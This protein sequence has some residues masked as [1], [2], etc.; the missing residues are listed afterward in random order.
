MARPITIEEQ[1]E[2]FNEACARYE[3]DAEFHYL[4]DRAVAFCVPK[5]INE[6]INA[7]M[8]EAATTSAAFALILAEKEV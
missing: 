6:S 1:Y 3:N 4:V 2:A 7:A 5:T 8:R